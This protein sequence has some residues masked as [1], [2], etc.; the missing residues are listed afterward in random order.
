MNTFDNVVAI[1][2]TNDIT[3]TPLRHDLLQILCANSKPLSAYQLLE[4]LKTIRPNAT[5]MTVYRTLK[6]FEQAHILHKIDKNNTFF[7]CC[8]PSS[9][10]DCQ[11]FSCIQCGSHQEVRNQ[12]I[13]QLIKKEMK[14][15][16]FHSLNEALQIPAL[17]PKC[18]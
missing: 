4:Q 13:T 3:I 6:V 11:I 14:K 15:I 16:G 17:C 5:P 8:H 9:E 1:L 7:L 18:V 12:Q 2:A 10:Q